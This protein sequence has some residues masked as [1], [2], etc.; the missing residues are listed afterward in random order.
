MCAEY[1]AA[2][3]TPEGEDEEARERRLAT[4]RQR[5]HRARE[6]VKSSLEQ[7]LE[8]ERAA[9]AAKAAREEALRARRAAYAMKLARRSGKDPSWEEMAPSCRAAA[10]AFGFM[11][12]MWEQ[13]DNDRNNIPGDSTIGALACSL[14]RKE[15]W[16]PWDELPRPLRLAANDLGYDRLAWQTEEFK[17]SGQRFLDWE[18]VE[19]DRMYVDRTYAC[20]VSSD[21]ELISGH[22]EGNGS[23]PYGPHGT[24]D[25]MDLLAQPSRRSYCHGVYAAYR[26]CGGNWIQPDVYSDPT[27]VYYRDEWSF[28]IR[29]L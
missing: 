13:R 7:Q 18:E 8:E 2:A 11:R 5:L 27:D 17:T 16:W 22:D 12:G 23:G 25:S 3:A 10:S 26:P 15:W 24:M 28:C 9:L 14:V 1:K 4:K 19:E 6:S 21:S 29:A 20:S